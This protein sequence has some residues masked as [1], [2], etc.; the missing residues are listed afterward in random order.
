MANATRFAACLLLLFAVLGA[1][2][3][4][5]EE[6][7]PLIS[8]DVIFANPD[9]AA[10]RISPDGR[11]LSFIAPVDGVMKVWVG[12]IDDWEAARPVTHDTG[13][14][15][16]RY[17]WAFDN[18][19]LLYLQDEGGNEN[20]RLDALD[21]V[22]RKV[23]QLT[24]ADGVAARIQQMSYK[25]PHEVLVSIN[26]RVP[27]LHDL[28]RVDIRTGERTLVLE[29]EGYAGFMTDDEFRVRFA[30]KMNMKGGSDSYRRKEDGTWEPFLETPMEDTLTTRPMGFDK[31]G[32]IMYLADSRGR[33][34]AAFTLLDVESGEQ[35]VLFED[36]RADIDGVSLHPTEKYVQAV[37]STYAR[38]E[39]HI[40]DPKMKADFEALG[41]VD[42]G[43]LRLTSRTLDDQQ[44]IVA[45]LRD[46]GAVRYYHYDRTAK[47]A[48]FLFTNMQALDDLELSPMHPV[49]IKSRDGLDL[50]SYL[51]LPSWC[52][53]DGDARPSKPLPM[54]LLVHGGPWARDSWGLNPFHQWL[55]NRG[56]AVLSVNF[57][58]ST[59]FGKAFVNASIKEWAGK[60]HDDLLDAV[61]WAEK[62]GI[63]D[64]EKVAIMGGS[65]GG[66]ATLVGLTKTPTRFACGVD[67]VGPSNLMTLLSTIPPYWAPL[68]NMFATR[69]GDPKT[70]EGRALLTERSPLTHVANIQR[71]LLIGQGKNDPR[72][73]E[74][75]ADQIV[76]AM[77]ARN[78][79]VTY[80]LYPDEGHGFRQPANNKSFNAIV[81]AFLARHLGGRHEPIG[82]D[83]EGASLQVGVGAEFVPGLTDA[84]GARG[85][86]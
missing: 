16:R 63:V 30:G 3:A 62:Q 82:D 22:T 77:R 15:I 85:D 37:S 72:V 69:V 21:L 45:S 78:I 24:P 12:P 51:T 42:D 84:L 59:G 27:A 2:P 65:Y 19:T 11:S 68:L 36:P 70:E 34:T 86:K 83:L 28:H 52:D 66:Y 20:W 71:P 29:N 50:V 35:T 64:P 79:P 9:R 76:D 38:T 40:L 43:D 60:M 26:D 54:V 61:A 74:S 75:E 46:D 57:R 53:A 44:W 14:G 41:Q 13:R 67:I 31:T 58:G 39:W 8:R 18:R 4:S 56:Y 48:R 55:A 33:N 80:V 23:V 25:H 1:A 10:V 49:V 6:A 81:E 73:K 32:K 47:K 5:A 17:Q 7:A